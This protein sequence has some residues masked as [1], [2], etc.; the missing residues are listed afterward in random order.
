MRHTIDALGNLLHGEGERGSRPALMM[1]FPMHQAVEVDHK[2]APKVA[3]EHGRSVAALSRQTT[4]SVDVQAFF[5]TIEEAPK[6]EV[7]VVLKSTEKRGFDVW[8]A[9]FDDNRKIESI[10]R[11]DALF[12]SPEELASSGNARW[13][14]VPAGMT[15]PGLERKY[16]SA[17][18]CAEITR[19]SRILR[20]FLWDVLAESTYSAKALVRIPT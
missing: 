3:P 20:V 7:A 4:A 15:L 9:R 19:S 12:Q 8:I 13:V 14:A 1:E 17:L 10:Q 16:G 6:T 18:Q 11:E 2:S 5:E